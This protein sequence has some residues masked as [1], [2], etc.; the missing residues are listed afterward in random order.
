MKKIII[1]ITLFLSLTNIASAEKRYVTERILLGIHKEADETSTLIKS[2]PSGTELEVLDTAEGFIEIKLEDG[3]EGWVSSGFVMEQTPA[4]RK[5]DVLAH[6][7]EQTTQELDKLK[8]D[9]EKNK[10]ELQVRRDQVSNAKTT[11][12]DLKKRKSGG[13]VVVDPEIEKKLTA[14]LQEVETLKLKVVELEKKPEP[15]P[16]IDQKQIFNELKEAKEQNDVM[17]KRIDVALAH[18]NGERIPT[19]EELASIRPKFPTWYWTLLVIILL[20]GVVAGYFIMDFRFRRRHGGFR[21]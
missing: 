6:Q 5:Y 21:I 8:V 18:L 10:R 11:I 12:Q 1:F 15:K 9:F 2:V 4:T 14:S 13:A 19:A 20:I 16:D 7:Y 17:K 3:T